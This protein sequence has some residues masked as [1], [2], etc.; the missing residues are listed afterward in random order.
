LQRLLDRLQTEHLSAQIE[1][2][3]ARRTEMQMKKSA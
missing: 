2:S 3:S 1:A